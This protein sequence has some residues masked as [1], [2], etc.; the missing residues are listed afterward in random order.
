MTPGRSKQVLKEWLASQMREF[1]DGIEIIAMDGFTGYTTA[2]AEEIPHAQAVM[3]PFHVASLAGLK[4]QECRQ[5]IQRATL[6]RRGR[7]GDPLYDIRR[8]LQTD[9]N[10]L[11]PKATSRLERA[12]ADPVHAEV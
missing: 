6:G 10:I 1:R 2:S 8:I 3:D 11:S 9:K 5:R 7:K 4:L 12:F